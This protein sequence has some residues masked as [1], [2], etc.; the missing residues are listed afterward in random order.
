M[1]ATI[2]LL[3]LNTNLFSQNCSINAGLSNT[4]CLNESLTLNGTRSGLFAPAA[5][6]NWSQ[7]S[8]PS[9]IIHSPDKLITNVSGYIAGNYVFRLSVKCRDG[10]IAEDFV[11]ITVLPL[12]LPDAG[13]DSVLCPNASTTLYANTPANPGETGRW[14]YVGSNA[15]GITI[16]APNN[17]RSPITINPSNAGTS[18]LR[19]TITTSNGCYSSDDVSITNYGGVDPVFAGDD[20]VLGNCFSTSTCANL[21]ASNGGRGLG[22]QIGEWSFVSGP[23]VPTIVQPASPG[24]RVCNLIEGTYVFRYTV[25][26]PCVTGADEVSVVVPPPGQISTVANSNSL[27]SETKYCG[28]VNSFTL[29]GNPPL[30]AGETVHWTQTS[31]SPLTIATPDNPSTVVNG[32]SQYGTYCFNYKIQ[33]ASSGCSST[34][35]VCYS[36]FEQGTVNGGPDQILPCDVTS[37]VIPTTTTG[38][39]TLNYRIISGPAGAF[40]SYPTG[41]GLFNDINGLNLPGTY[42]VEVNYSFGVGCPAVSDYV[43]VTV[44]RTPTGTNAGTDLYFACSSSTAQLAGNNPTLTGLGTGRWSQVVGPTTAS[45]TSPINYITDVKG[46]IPGV[47]TFRWTVKGGNNCPSNSDDVKVFIPD[48]LITSANLGPDKVVCSNSPIVLQGNSLHADETAQWSVEPGGV[49]FSPSVNT[50]TPT[51]TG[52]TPATTYTFVYTINNSCGSVSRDTM[53]ITTSASS[54]PSVANAG[55]DQ[56]LP[57]GTANIQLN[58]VRPTSGLGSWTQIGGTPVTISDHT[59]NSTSVSGVVNG[60]Y[61]FLWTVSVDG[62][63]NTTTDTVVVTVSGNTTAANAGTDATIC[64]TVYTLN[65]NTPV[66][67]NGIWSQI[68]GDG[69]AVITQP[70]NPASTITNLSTGI[71]IFRWT[72]NNGVCPSTH[73]ELKIT[74]SSPPSV[75]NAGADQVLCG[76]TANMTQLNA[77]APLIGTGQWV[78]V[79][80]PNIARITNNTLTQTTVTG[81]TNGSYTFRWIVA[82]GPSCPPSTDDVVINISIPANAGADQNLCNLSS[83]TLRGNTGSAGVWSQISGPAA[84]ISQSPANNPIASVSGLIPGS[85]YVFRYTIPASFGCPETFDEM[86]INNRTSTQI[87][88]AGNDTSFCNSITIPLNGSIP[89]DGETGTWSLLS[90][91]SGVQFTPNANTPNATM[92]NA[93][94]GVYTLKWTVSNGTCSSSDIKRIDNY[95]PPTISN[96]GRDQTVCFGKTV[97]QANTP[98][99]GIGKWVQVSGPKN[100]TIASVNNPV[101]EVSGLD[102]DGTYQLVWTIINGAVCPASRDTVQLIVSALSPTVSNAGADQNLCQ[103]DAVMLSANTPLEGTGT[104]LQIS[105]PQ[106]DIAS[107]HAPYSTVTSLVT[108]TYKFVWTI[109]N[110]DGS[111]VSRDTITVINNPQPNIADAGPDEKFCAF[112]SVHLA[113]NLPITGTTGRWTLISGPNTPIILSPSV[114]NSPVTG[115]IPGVYTFRWTISSPSCSPTSDEVVFTIINAADLARCR[116]NQDICSSVAALHA[117]TP[118][119]SN[120]GIWEQISGPNN[121]LFSLINSPESQLS[122]LIPGIYKLVWKIYNEKCFT[123]DTLII[124][125]Q[126]PGIVDAGADVAVCNKMSEYRLSASSFGGSSTSAVWTIISGNGSLSNTLPTTAPYLVSFFPDTS[127][128]GPVV[129]RLTANDGCSSAVSDDVTLNMVPSVTTPLYAANDVIQLHSVAGIIIPVLDNDIGL[130][131]DSIKLCNEQAIVVY[132]TNGTVVVQNDGSIHYSP[133]GFIKLDS[134]RYQVC[135][136]G[137]SDSIIANGCPNESTAI[138]WV[139]IKMDECLVPNTITPNGDGINDYFVMPCTQNKMEFVVFNSWGEELYSSEDYQN[140]WDGNYNGAPLPSGTYFYSLRYKNDDELEVNKAGFISLRR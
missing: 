61:T 133:N 128:T 57:A 50:P 41:Y 63:N 71:Y 67:G 6:V 97:L 51:I 43:D 86:V 77:T 87:P 44:S 82:G 107:E 137:F 66:N 69:D 10:Y 17:P 33:N 124:T 56:C 83:A 117:N 60:T 123:T 88:D 28:L 118:S 49:T 76:S 46:L 116:Y 95:A 104:W 29:R 135:F 23:S 103:Q 127:Y 98:L 18:V 102:M 64:S 101:T 96:A 47:Y 21:L 120:Q 111:C 113:A 129:L 35:L 93:V 73:D 48:T 81:L 85:S 4:I 84:T 54:G 62:C 27:G 39:G 34:N 94:T 132:P 65:G 52:L 75:A 112:G 32:I 89:A 55:A 80:G 19:W 31:G 68:S 45:I 3:V 53:K 74:A 26:G 59:N 20:Q 9:V 15:A 138:A 8:G 110:A 126:P 100:L 58:A 11:T 38:A 99:N 40:S 13:R 2:L 90:G 121:A 105:G 22:G 1:L 140:N 130:N 30:Y 5:V 25:T 106:A 125:V 131:A 7:V 114:P 36:F 37:T 119:G 12:T 70:D 24:T 91:P 134:F 78:Q 108:D 92:I 139:F 122:G 16:L 72:I 79:T 115:V 109:T 42:R 14:T 136:A